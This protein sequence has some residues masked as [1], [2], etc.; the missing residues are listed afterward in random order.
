M[1]A[2]ARGMLPHPRPGTASLLPDFPPP[3]SPP[4]PVNPAPRKELKG[5]HASLRGHRVTSPPGAGRR[6]QRLP[7]ARF[8]VPAWGWESRWGQT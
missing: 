2:H 6:T 7:S 3:F 5:S 8:R 4:P 1:Q